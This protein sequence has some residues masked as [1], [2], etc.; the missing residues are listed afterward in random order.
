M[1]LVGEVSLIAII[2]LSHMVAVLALDDFRILMIMPFLAPVLSAIT[3]TDCT[4]N[5]DILLNK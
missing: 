3:T 1:V 5:I 2:T 4:F